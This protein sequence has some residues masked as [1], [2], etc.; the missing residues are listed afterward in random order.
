ML[1]HHLEMSMSGYCHIRRRNGESLLCLF[2]PSVRRSPLREWELTLCDMT[3]GK[4]IA[5]CCAMFYH[6]Y[7]TRCVETAKT[8]IVFEVTLKHSVFAETQRVFSSCSFCKTRSCGNRPT[9]T[10]NSSDVSL[11][12]KK[13]SLILKH[14]QVKSNP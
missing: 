14:Q 13:S 11:N 6:T 4:N 5:R 1:S 7:H 3:R 10:S 9:I 8:Q 12:I 2:C